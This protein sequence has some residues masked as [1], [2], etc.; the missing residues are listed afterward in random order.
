MD[1]AAEAEQILTETA[2]M[3]SEPDAVSV[4]YAEPAPDAMSNMMGLMLAV[5]LLAAIYTI[6]IA[7]A[8]TQDTTPVLLTAVQE[9]IW[10]VLI[11]AAVV[12]LLIMA[13]GFV[14]GGKSRTP[15]TA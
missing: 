11:G 9:I 15:K 13:V 6:I 3:P 8:A 4:G 12:A 1:V 2:A 5:P 7:F 14:F 10:F